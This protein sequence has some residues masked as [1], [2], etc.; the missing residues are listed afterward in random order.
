MC[1]CM[2]E[3]MCVWETMTEFGAEFVGWC[4]MCVCARM[5]TF[6]FCP[7][8]CACSHMHEC[9]CIGL[10]VCACV[11]TCAYIMKNHT[12]HD[13][14]HDK[15]LKL[16]A[17][18]ANQYRSYMHQYVCHTCTYISCLISWRYSTQCYLCKS[19]SSLIHTSIGLLNQHDYS[20]LCMQTC[21]CIYMRHISWLTSFH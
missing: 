5:Q 13:S 16:S 15:V 21:T 9:R 18:Y 6:C 17:I 1:A 4:G 12:F 10:C 11:Q 3:E 7:G 2:H 8:M 20:F 14:Y 19:M